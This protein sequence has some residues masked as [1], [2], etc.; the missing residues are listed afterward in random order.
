MIVIGNNIIQSIEVSTDVFLAGIA[1]QLGYTV[2]ELHRARKKRTGSSVVSSSVRV[3]TTRRKKPE[4]YE[5]A[6]E[7]RA[8]DRKG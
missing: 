6:V 3:G 5:T 8:P 1:E 4:L 2:V 7:L